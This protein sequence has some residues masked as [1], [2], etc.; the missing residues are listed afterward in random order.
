M[1]KDIIYK[2]GIEFFLA[3]F[4]IMVTSVLFPHVL[5]VFMTLILLKMFD[6]FWIMK[7][8]KSFPNC[9]ISGWTH[10]VPSFENLYWSQEAIDEIKALRMNRHLWVLLNLSLIM[11][12]SKVTHN[13]FV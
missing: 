2:S 3:T 10:R 8:E 4:I 5:G 12:L 6:T 1:S 13:F 7:A 11:I 9:P